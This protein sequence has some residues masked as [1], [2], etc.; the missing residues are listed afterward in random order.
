VV[1]FWNYSREARASETQR[2]RDSRYKG[3]SPCL[4]QKELLPKNVSSSMFS[5]C[6]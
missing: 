1:H 3:H 2:L 6:L 4:I 5:L